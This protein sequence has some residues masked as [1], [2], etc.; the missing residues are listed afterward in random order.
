MLATEICLTGASARVVPPPTAE[1][2]IPFQIRVLSAGDEIEISGSFSW[3]LP[4]NVEAVL[5]SA[6][7]ARVVRLESPG[8][9]LLPAMQIAS[10]IQRRGL[11]T[12]VGR[13]C[14]SA[15]TIAFLGGQQRWVAPDAKLGFHQANA[16][17]FPPEQANAFLRTIYETFTV[18]PPF[19]AHVL[20]TS[21]HDVWYPSQN[22][23]R[24]NHFTTGAPPA[25]VLALG[26]SPLQR[27][28]DFTPLLRV[29]P[30]DAVSEF[31]MVFSDLLVRLRE[32]NP[33]ACWAFA[34]DGPDDPLASLPAPIPDIIA[35]AWT[36]LTAVANA[37]RDQS[38]TEDQRK[39]A[40]TDLLGP[41]RATGR[42]ASLSGLRPGADHTAF[43]NSLGELLQAALALPEPRRGSA[44]RAVLFGG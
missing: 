43:C 26:M 21:Y 22:E 19:I 12:Y 35:S 32:A 1:F 33:E 16:P 4:Q 5:A 13:F 36:R 31:A 17:G 6:P 24:A 27:L 30:D 38:P 9:H 28:K 11:D 34:H 2:D 41:F 40:L 10:I 39:K 7:N 8:G 23:L 42:E 29:A 25:S 18:P 37:T 14:A 20:R 44:L 3:A 15:C